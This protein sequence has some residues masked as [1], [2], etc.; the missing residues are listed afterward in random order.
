MCVMMPAGCHVHHYVIQE[1]GTVCQWY[2]SPNA[3][4]SATASFALLQIQLSSV[5]LARKY[6]QL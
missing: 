2:F 6:E 4:Q 3:T 1:T 5:I